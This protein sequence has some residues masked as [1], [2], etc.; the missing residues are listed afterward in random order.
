VSASVRDGLGEVIRGRRI[1]VGLTQE[2]LAERSG[3][4]VRAIRDIERG[5]TGRPYRRSVDLLSGVLGLPDP[6]GGEPASASRAG[7]GELD[8]PAQAQA[9]GSASGGHRGRIVPRQLPV[10]IGHFAGRLGELTALDG[11]LG[12]AAGGPGTVVISA[13]GGTAGVG[14]SALAV[15]WGHR[16]AGLFPDGQLYVNL[17]GFDP[18]GVPVTPSAALRGFLAALS[19]PATEI[20]LTLEAQTGLYRSLVAGQRMLIVLDNARDTEQVRPLLPASAACSVLVTSRNTLAGLAVTEGAQLLSLDVLSE[21][22]AGELLSGRL[23]PERVHGEPQAVSELI[24]LCARLPLALAVVAA[25]AAAGP[26]RSLAALVEELRQAHDR[27]DVLDAGD[28]ATSVRAVFSW[29]YQSLSDSAARMFRLLGAHPGPD[30]SA[31]AAASLAGVGADQ[32]RRALKELALANLLAECPDG[33]FAFHDLLR[34]YAAELVGGSEHDADRRAALHRVLDFYVQT[35][36][37]ADRLLHPTRSWVSLPPPRPG[38]TRQDFSSHGEALRWLQAEHQ[39]LLA[40]IASAA[41]TGFGS[42]AWQISGALRTF[43]DRQAHWQDWA[44]SQHIGLTAAQ[45]AGDVAGQAHSHRDLG[46]ACTRLGSYPDAHAHL[47]DALDLYRQM[48]DHIGQGNAHLDVARVYE[49]EGRAGQ[50]LRQCEQALQLYRQAAHPVG[51]ARALNGIGWYHAVLGNPAQTLLYCRPPLDTFREL[52]DRHGE[53]STL[54]SLG[55][56]HFRLG[57]YQDAIA[58]FQEAHC[59]FREL[60]DRYFQAFILMRL[61]DVHQAARNRPAARTAWRQALTI[62]DELRHPD[63]SGVRAKLRGCGASPSRANSAGQDCR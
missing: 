37:G 24:G 62:L 1:A 33:R 5:R 49:A 34:A 56:A 4:S 17:R 7:P 16:V 47:R 50:A 44:A 10:A 32:A 38:V 43:F 9:D 18:S 2:E 28:A 20:P 45:R 53:A 19:V 58:C 59:R 26:R 35:T 51:E 12:E 41:D 21:A 40:A 27:L 23:G 11:L 57:H 48:G 30:V 22:E 14:K 15:H 25:R 52:G 60:E 42:Y 46:L 13:I 8:T 6:V 55:Y 39:V 29:S 36:W 54:D 31:L 63:A 61:G 3:L